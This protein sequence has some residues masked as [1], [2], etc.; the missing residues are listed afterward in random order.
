MATWATTADNQCYSGNTLQEA[1]STGGAL[2][3]K[4]GGTPI[5][6]T[7][8]MLTTSQ[9]ESMVNV[10]AISAAS[11]QLPTKGETITSDFIMY[12]GPT[13][14]V[15]SSSAISC[16]SYVSVR[17]YYIGWRQGGNPS[18]HVGDI[19][20]DTYNTVKTNGNGLWVPL[21]WQGTGGT[22]SVRVST[23]GVVLEVVNC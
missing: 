10:F 13:N 20:Y 18:V 15:Y 11:N 9:V 5:P 23:T 17:P 14:P 19:L 12:M 1:V 6:A 3:A 16:V 8:E 22:F 2:I 7:A 21:K 4:T